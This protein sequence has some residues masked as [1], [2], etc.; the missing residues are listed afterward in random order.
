MNAEAMPASPFLR[1]LP[2]RDSRRFDPIF[3]MV[4]DFTDLSF[5]FPSTRL[6]PMVLVPQW[7]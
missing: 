3:W 2:I 6:V 5:F 4:F 7:Q 1:S